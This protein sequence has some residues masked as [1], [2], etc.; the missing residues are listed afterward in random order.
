MPFEMR[1][2]LSR[3]VVAGVPFVR[4]CVHE[5]SPKCPE[6]DGEQ[7]ADHR[8]RPTHTAIVRETNQTVK[9]EAQLAH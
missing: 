9:L 4:V 3:V 7:Q 8:Q 2:N 6:G 1:V 5:R